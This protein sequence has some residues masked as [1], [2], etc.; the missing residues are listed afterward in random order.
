MSFFNG[1]LRNFIVKNF[2]SMSV[3]H[4]PVRS[5][6]I[7]DI[8]EEPL[9]MKKEP[10]PEPEPEEGKEIHVE[11]YKYLSD[12]PLSREF[13]LNRDFTK[14]HTLHLCM[15]KINKVLSYPFLEFYLIKGTGQYEFPHKVLSPEIFKDVENEGVT[16]DR[17]EPLKD[18]EIMKKEEEG[19][20]DIFLDQCD[21][22]FKEIIRGDEIVENISFFSM[23]FPK[24][25]VV[26]LD[27][28][29][30]LSK[31]YKGFVEK[32]KNIFAVYDCSDLSTTK[33]KGSW[34]TLSEILDRKK[35][36]NNDISILSI[37]LLK[38]SRVIPNIK[39]GDNENL[40]RPLV[41]YLCKKTDEG[42]M[43]TQSIAPEGLSVQNLQNVYYEG[44]ENTNTTVTLINERVNHPIL[45][46]VYLF[47][48]KIFKSENDISKIKRFAIYFDPSKKIEGELETE[49]IHQ[50]S[51]F[52]DF[53]ELCSV[54]SM[55]DLGFSMPLCGSEKPSVIGFKEDGV[56]YVCTKSPIYFVE[57]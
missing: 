23:F 52:V 3:S 9:D 32:G 50:E 12:D 8:D 5:I 17:I 48:D 43:H 54:T 10:E 13:G 39:N 22:L 26:T 18:G 45:R 7:G 37:D 49:N 44:E 19:V 33:L 57:L 25:N 38:E 2:M 53:T 28:K 34:V 27:D 6:T 56:D 36:F 42:V 31:L 35:I 46:Q 55:N 20:E 41:L 1:E 16:D 30:I 29:D 40:P 21:D 51:S 14:P 47:T 15:Y 4:E 11:E 24:E